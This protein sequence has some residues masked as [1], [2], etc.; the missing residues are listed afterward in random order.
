MLHVH[1]RVSRGHEK[2]MNGLEIGKWLL[3][4]SMTKCL[5]A[6]VWEPQLYFLPTSVFFVVCYSDLMF[7]KYDV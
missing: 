7:D 3:D 4:W 5:S 2:L 1:N 6:S